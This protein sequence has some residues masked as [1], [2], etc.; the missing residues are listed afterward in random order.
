M[1]IRYKGVKKNIVTA[2]C[3]FTETRNCIDY[4]SHGMQDNL[5]DYQPESGYKSWALHLEDIIPKSKVYNTA[6]PGAGNG[7]ISRAVIYKVEQLLELNLK[8]D[9][10]C[11][12]LTAP[13]RE[14]FLVDIIDA[15]SKTDKNLLTHFI[16]AL[17]GGDTGEGNINWEAVTRI[18]KNMMWLKHSYAKE[19]MSKYHYK[20][21]SNEV[22]SVTKTLEHIL[23]LQWYFKSKDIKYKMFG[24]WNIFYQLPKIPRYP[25]EIRHL[26]KMIDWDNFWFHKKL[27]GITEWSV[28]NLPFEERYITGDR[29]NRDGSAVDEHP[30]NIA[31]NKFAKEV[32]SKW[33]NNI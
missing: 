15:S 33:I 11:V 29:K 21:Y 23:R 1:S 28:D 25:I 12:Q 14:E 3:S 7:Y 24:G 4:A 2:G 27:G 5:D 9:Y 17:D 32:V 22:F 20:Y 16:P 26:W 18:N 31:H 6:L 10:V 13:E 8:V 30:S 19:S